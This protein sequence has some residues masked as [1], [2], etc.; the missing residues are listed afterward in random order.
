MP[1]LPE[2]ETIA[3]NIAGGTGNV[4]SV[5]GKTVTGA[6]VTWNRII[7]EPDA[8]AFRH[9]ILGQEIKAVGRRAKYLVFTLSDG[10]MLIHLRMSGDL[11]VTPIGETPA[12]HIRMFLELDNCWQLSFNNPRKF[13]RVWLLE[14][15]A[16]LLNDL[17][18]EPFDPDLTPE[19]FSAML[20]SRR[21]QI[22][23]LLLDQGFIAG[24]GNIYTDEAL[25]M[26][27]IHPLASSHEVTPAQAAKLL[28]SIRAVLEEGIR[29]NGSSI[30]WVYQGGDYQN[31]F[32]VYQRAGEPC[33]VC[34]TPVEK[35]VV[36]QRGTHICPN[37]QAF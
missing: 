17:G 24:M 28:E 11:F 34:G 7:A 37:C 9:L 20:E 33:P 31:Y 3:R 29:R 27:G 36:G 16:I 23:P 25:H 26:A 4:P 5:I 12:G 19:K 8:E 30:D 1:E 13:G 2:V 15:P 21:R 22:K 6:H 32:R 10:T 18:P 14:S 35:T